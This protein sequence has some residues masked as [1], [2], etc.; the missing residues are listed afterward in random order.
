MRCCGPRRIGIL[1]CPLRTCFVPAGDYGTVPGN[2]RPVRPQGGAGQ[3]AVLSPPAHSGSVPLRVCVRPLFLSHRHLRTPLHQRTASSGH[4]KHRAGARYGG[5]RTFA[6]RE[7]GAVRALPQRSL[8][9][10][11]RVSPRVMRRLLGN[12]HDRPRIVRHHYRLFSGVHRQ[13]RRRAKHHRQSAGPAGGSGSAAGQNGIYSS[14]CQCPWPLEARNGSAHLSHSGPHHAIH[15]RE[16]LHCRV[17]CPYPC[18]QNLSKDRI[19]GP[20]GTARL[21]RA[22]LRGTR[23]QPHRR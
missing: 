6:Q 13:G 2:R 17:D 5:R 14:F 9:I 8:T 15:S 1:L 19:S 23:R 3:I 21:L 4:R 16:A 18:A 20:H 22:V 7:P 12:T 10:R 11:R